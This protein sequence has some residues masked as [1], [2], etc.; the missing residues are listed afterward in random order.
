MFMPAPTLL[1][2]LKTESHLHANNH[3]HGY[4]HDYGNDH[5]NNEDHDYDEGT[6]QI[7]VWSKSAALGQC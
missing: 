6:E 2:A 7:H 5:N 4:N 1:Q 3:D